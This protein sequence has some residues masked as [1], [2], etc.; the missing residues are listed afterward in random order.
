MIQ[1]NTSTEFK[2]IRLKREKK[3]KKGARRAC[4]RANADFYR[5]SQAAFENREKRR[6][7]EGK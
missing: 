1:A 3:N 2:I 7:K 6:E 4:T 5:G